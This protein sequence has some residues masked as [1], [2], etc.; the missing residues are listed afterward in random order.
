MTDTFDYQMEINL[1]NLEDELKAAEQQYLQK[2]QDIVS[3][4]TNKAKELREAALKQ[5]E[6]ILNNK[7]YKEHTQSKESTRDIMMDSPIKSSGCTPI[8][9][10]KI[11]ESLNRGQQLYQINR[12]QQNIQ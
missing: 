10:Q 4:Y 6:N 5:Y 7:T 11:R 2:L 9:V 1:K 8:H 12:K 3:K